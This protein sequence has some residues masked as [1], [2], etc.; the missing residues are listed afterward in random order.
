MIGEIRK[1][2]REV[3]RVQPTEYGGHQLVDCRVWI[4]DTTDGQETPTKKGLCLRPEQWRELVPLLQAAVGEPDPE[5]QAD[6]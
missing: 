6:E 3:V 1:N 2:S 5:V 4:V